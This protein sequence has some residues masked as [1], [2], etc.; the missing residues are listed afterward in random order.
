MNDG[1]TYV[2]VSTVEQLDRVSLDYQLKICNE[3]AAKQNI[4]VQHVFREEGES[5]KTANRTQLIRAIEYCRKHKGKI[6]YFIVYK[7]DRFARNS[8]DHYAIRSMLAKV[9]VRLASA[10]EP[11]DESPAG[12]FMESMLAAAS[13]FDNGVRSER[14]RGGMQARLAQGGWV[15]KAPLG[16]CNHRDEQGRPTLTVDTATG[17]LVAQ[18]LHEFRTNTYTQREIGDYAWSIGLVSYSGRRLGYQAIGK[19]L[20]NP[21]YAGLIRSSMTTSLVKGLHPGLITEAEYY[22]IQAKLSPRFAPPEHHQLDHPAYP[23]R[24][25][26]L[27]CAHCG[28]SLAGSAPKGRS[29]YYPRYHCLT[30]KT[31]QTGRP[32]SERAE[33]VHDQFLALLHQI[34]P[35]PGVLDLIKEAL[36]RRWNQELRSQRTVRQSLDRR[37]NEVEEKV[38]HVLDLYIDHKLSDSQ[39]E[40]QLARLENQLMEL[41]I[42]QGEAERSEINKDTVL[43]YAVNF[44]ANVAK[45]WTDMEPPERLHF[46]QL[47]FPDGLAY[48]FGN[49]FWNPILGLAFEVIQDQQTNK[50]NLVAQD[51]NV[52]HQLKQHLQALADFIQRLKNRAS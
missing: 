34:S 40:R 1:V 24:R 7:L 31:R 44:M 21:I 20:R 33:I 38:S 32:I 6:K 36:I 37:V 23:L 8:E 49:G 3:F 35:R 52:W 48:E 41:R 13:E 19:L 5:A 2:R 51:D 22:Q 30:C 10:T 26:F 39:K 17:S 11:I 18:V 28:T 25:G 9:G 16:F 46:L 45:L 50:S 14:S 47:I 43:G 15:H 4:R 42:A 29:R 27:R 12:K